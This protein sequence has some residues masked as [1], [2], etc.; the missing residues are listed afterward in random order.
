MDATT[1][2]IASALM[3]P[4]W[5]GSGPEHWQSRWEARHGDR[6][7][8]QDDWE[9]PVRE[10][11]TGRLD[12]AL[13]AEATPA[14]LVAHSLGCHLVAAWAAVADDPGR[15]RA[16]LLVAPPDIDRDDMPPILHGWRPAPGGALPFPSVVVASSDDPYCALASARALAA[17]WGGELVDAGDRGHMNSE[18][19]LGDWPEGRGLLSRLIARAV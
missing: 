3:L 1:P 12:E 9:R 13:R 6:R 11:W 5:M 4:G 2:T 15:V 7:V 16:A 8:E 17:G 14:V 18:S 10:A 19:G